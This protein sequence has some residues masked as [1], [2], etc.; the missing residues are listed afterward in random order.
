MR[1][2]GITG[3][4]GAGKTTALNVL[5]ALGAEVID[6][7][8]VYHALLAEDEEL[9]KTLVDAFGAQ[10]LDP[11]GGI[12]RKALSAAVY[13][14]RLEELNSLTHPVIVRAVWEKV[15]QARKAG[16]SAA[17]D[18]I[19][20]VEC[21]LGAKCDAVVAVLA[22]LELRVRRIMARDGITEAYARR[23]AL[24]Q[25]PDSFFL[26]NAHYV[27]EN[28]ECDTPESFARRSETLFS[29]L[30]RSPGGEAD[31]E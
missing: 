28:R 6:A 25:K 17:I 1:V 3:P 15:E 11:A 29:A 24:A 9:K 13:P 18:A 27:L 22:P 19:A 8:A 30:L 20:L 23:R 16:R 4:T 10:I 7:D 31:R 5:R 12:D 21:G 26:E 14:D 2:I